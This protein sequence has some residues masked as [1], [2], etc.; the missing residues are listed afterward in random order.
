[1]KDKEPR[2]TII[3]ELNKSLKDKAIENADIPTVQ[4]IAASIGVTEKM[5]DRWLHEP[6]GQLARELHNITR[7]KEINEE[8]LTKF[9]EFAWT[10]EEKR[11]IAE[12]TGKEPDNIEGFTEQFHIFNA[13]AGAKERHHLIN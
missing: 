1:M 10:E 11:I 9:P 7:L 3:D 13:I 2:L 8:I 4:S 5:L 12:A 6:D